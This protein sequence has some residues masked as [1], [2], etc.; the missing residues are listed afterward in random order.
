MT[1][2]QNIAKMEA[3][4][5]AAAV[6][7]LVKPYVMARVDVIVEQM[8]AIYRGGVM[9]H[10]VLV[11]KLGEITGLLDLIYHL[12]HVQKIGDNA[13]QKEIGNAEAG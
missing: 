10:D 5:E 12:E 3:G 7:G 8:V 9:P 4:R 6:D 11:G 1:Q 2:D 13:A